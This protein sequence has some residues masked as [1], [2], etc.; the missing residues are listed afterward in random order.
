V[1]EHDLYQTRKV[2]A[3]RALDLER[4][5]EG[6]DYRVM[7]DTE[8][9]KTSRMGPLLESLLLKK[10]PTETKYTSYLQ[11]VRR[12]SK[13]WPI[14]SDVSPTIQIALRMTAWAHAAISV[15]LRSA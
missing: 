2:Q 9:V 7:T 1:I 3:S 4:A 12:E 10:N 8:R 11:P 14:I 6:K 15:Q 13:Y 5:W